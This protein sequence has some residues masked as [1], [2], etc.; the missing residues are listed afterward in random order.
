MCPVL[1][2]LLSVDMKQGIAIPR[3]CT[4]RGLVLD[5]ERIAGWSELVVD[6]DCRELVACWL[7]EITSPVSSKMAVLW[8]LTSSPA[9][10]N[11]PVQ[12]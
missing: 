4:L 2:A 11:P 10:E 6:V 8:V 12:V 3:G 1:G 7:A 5:A 9:A